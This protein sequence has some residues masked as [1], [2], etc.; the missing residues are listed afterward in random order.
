MPYHPDVC[1]SCGIKIKPGRS[2]CETCCRPL[3]VSANSVLQ[4]ETINISNKKRVGFVFLIG[5]LFLCG[6]VML[7]S[8]AYM[9]RETWLPPAQAFL[10]SANQSQEQQPAQPPTSQVVLQP[11]SLPAATAVPSMLTSLTLAPSFPTLIP[12]STIIMAN[13]PDCE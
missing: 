6:C 11:T 4:N 7:V 13:E 2:F 10:T 1:P 9:T 12:P 8:G 3:S 5:V